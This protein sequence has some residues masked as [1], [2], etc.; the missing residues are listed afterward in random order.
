MMLEFFLLC[1][2]DTVDPRSLGERQR[3]RR[4]DANIT[5]E[6]NRRGLSETMLYSNLVKA[7]GI[8]AD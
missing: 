3:T 1:S 6:V 7:H 2:F 5:A 4:A 8:R